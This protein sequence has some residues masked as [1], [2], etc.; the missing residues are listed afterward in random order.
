MPKVPPTFCWLAWV[1]LC[2][3]DLM[4]RRCHRRTIGS[5]QWHP[6]ACH[7]AT[8]E[9][10][11]AKIVQQEQQ[12]SEP[13]NVAAPVCMVDRRHV[14]LLM[15]LLGSLLLQQDSG[16]SKADMCGTGQ[17]LNTFCI[18]HPIAPGTLHKLK[19]ESL[20]NPFSCHSM[21]DHLMTM[22]TTMNH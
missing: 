9:D 22:E 10:M 16:W 11:N 17:V 8:P 2:A 21:I 3:C 14:C 1:G 7:T 6:M 12:G 4:L 5:Y 18:F 20:L 15:C 13:N 19:I